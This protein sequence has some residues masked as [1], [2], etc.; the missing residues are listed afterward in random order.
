MAGFIYIISSEYE[1]EMLKIG[2]TEQHPDDRLKQLNSTGVAHLLYLRATFPVYDVRKAESLVHK[3]LAPHRFRNDR[4]FFVLPLADAIILT[5]D[6]L[7]TSGQLIMDEVPLR[8]DNRRKYAGWFCLITG[9]I[10]SSTAEPDEPLGFFL[11]IAGFILLK[12]HKKIFEWMKQLYKIIRFRI[13]EIANKDKE[14]A[15]STRDYAGSDTPF[16]Q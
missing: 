16:P 5:E 9:V 11:V 13:K 4:E 10:M 3:R 15:E 14:D 7:K 12:W 8:K 1:P 6:V 2:L